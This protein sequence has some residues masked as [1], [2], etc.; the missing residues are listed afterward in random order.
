MRTLRSEMIRYTEYLKEAKAKPVV[1]TFG[2]F[3]PITSGHEIA[4]NDIIKQAKSKGGTPMIFTSQAQ[5]KKK[6]P[7]SYNDKTKYLKAFWGKMIVKDRKIISA[8]DA[9]EWLSDNGYKNVT[10]VVG[11]DRV[12]EFEK[13]IRP[14]IKHKDKKKSYEFDHFEVIQ[15]GVARG[16]SNAM[17]ASLMRKAA[18]D[19][20]FDFYK[21]GVPSMAS[22]KDAREMYDAVRSA[23]GLKE[24][25]LEFGRPEAT[26]R[27]KEW[28]P[29]EV[30]ELKIGQH[31]KG[32]LRQAKWRD[33]ILPKKLVHAFKRYVHQ[34]K[35][36]EA[37]KIYKKLV[38]EYDDNPKAYTLPG[39][40]VLNPKGRALEITS[41]LV[42]ISIGELKK[43]FDRETRYN[44]VNH[45]KNT[46]FTDYLEEEI[47][48]V[49]LKQVEAFADEIF[50]K[51]G[52]DVE[53]TKHFLQR[54]NDKRNGKEI[55]IAELTR[56]FKQTYKKYGK[57]IPKLG[58][59]AQAVLNDTQTDL[60]LPFVL[61]WDEK[62]QEFDLISKTIMRKKEFKTSNPKLKV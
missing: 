12:A 11:S 28:T 13:S 17:S 53:F 19:G 61:K 59:N 6:N 22:V 9:L 42:G 48:K 39:L 23:M 51:V 49:D 55:N 56:L 18:E 26:K 24:E 37:M 1:F 27:Y 57:K 30:D 34:N 32:P 54:A 62:S 52:I 4:I 25:Y 33:I 40:L 10:M 41:E 14:Y 16:K 58:D 60:N 43:V 5:D 36:A 38:K 47:T 2:R 15:A 35:Y 21:K 8:F 7:L 29:G 31:H 45:E 46:P 3:N 44:S 50:A 20:D